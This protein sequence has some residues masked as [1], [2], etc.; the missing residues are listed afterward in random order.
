MREH[1]V[2]HPVTKEGAKSEVEEKLRK[3]QADE[4]PD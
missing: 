2:V 3:Q 1:E 4:A